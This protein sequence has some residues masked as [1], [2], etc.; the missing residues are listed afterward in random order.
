MAHIIKVSGKMELKMVKEN[1]KTFK[2]TQW[3]WESG[4]TVNKLNGI[5][6]QNPTKY[7]T[8]R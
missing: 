8:I 4:K 2:K 3:S 5:C 7:K 1:L 6:E